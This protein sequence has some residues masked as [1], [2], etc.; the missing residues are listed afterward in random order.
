MKKSVLACELFQSREYFLVNTYQM[1]TTTQLLI[2]TILIIVLFW[3]MPDRKVR[4]IFGEARKLFQILPM[5]KIT[6]AIIR[7][8]KSKQ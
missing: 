2:W 3:M 8:F 7:Y 1:E 5:S 4:L 6:E